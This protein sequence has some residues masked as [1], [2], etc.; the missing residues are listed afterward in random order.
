MKVACNEINGAKKRGFLLKNCSVILYKLP[1][2]NLIKLQPADEL[3]TTKYV[4]CDKKVYIHDQN[5]SSESLEKVSCSLVTETNSKY[6][7]CTSAS[8]SSL[9]IS[10]QP[11]YEVEAGIPLKKIRTKCNSTNSSENYTDK[12]GKKNE[13]PA[14]QNAKRFTCFHCE[15]GY[16]E[17]CKLIAHMRIHT[18]E[19]PY[20]CNKCNKSFT[21]KQFLRVHEYGHSKIRTFVCSYCNK[22]F[23]F[24]SA[25][26]THIL[27]HKGIKKSCCEVCGNRF[28]SKEKLNE[29]IL[30]KHDNF[31]DFNLSK[32]TCSRCSTFV[33]KYHLERHEATH[34][35]THNKNKKLECLDCGKYYSSGELLVRHQRLHMDSECRPYACGL[36]GK[37]FSNQGNVK[38]HF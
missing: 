31:S 18:G 10:R 32:F 4:L 27:R 12:F 15:T 3:T 17:K 22:K 38:Q 34:N 6:F 9:Q 8:T 13:I 16:N 2:I 11:N 36:C 26:R 25:L 20:T 24:P 23:T 14:A 37:A 35:K 1:I 30:R 33:R 19:K 21:R 29:H 5:S 7:K 28:F